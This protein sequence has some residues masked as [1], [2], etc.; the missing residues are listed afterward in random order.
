MTSD[1][2]MTSPDHRSD[3]QDARRAGVR[4]TALIVAAIAAVVYIGFILSGVLST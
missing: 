3:E 4:R 1:L 2:A